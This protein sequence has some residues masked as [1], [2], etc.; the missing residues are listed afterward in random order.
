MSKLNGNLSIFNQLKP[1]SVGFENMFDS[2]EKMFEDDG[3]ESLDN[4]PYYNIVKTGDFT[5][6]IEV[7]LA[8]FYIY[9]LFFKYIALKYF[10]KIIEHRGQL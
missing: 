9:W 8:G 5:Y 6:D 2:F 4:Y 1:V 3:F 7:A 10:N